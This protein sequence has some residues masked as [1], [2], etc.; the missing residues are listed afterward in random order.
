[1]KRPPPPSVAEIDALFAAISARAAS[2]VSRFGLTRHQAEGVI[3]DAARVA[4]LR[5]ATSEARAELALSVIEERASQ[6]AAEAALAA[7]AR[8]AG[9]DVEDGE[10]DPA[11]TREERDATVH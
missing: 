8:A 1:M 10:D 9:A 3:W 5:A 11:T 7:A 4:C 6:L 2:L